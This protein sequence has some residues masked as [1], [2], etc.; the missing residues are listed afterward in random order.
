MS[1]VSTR[2]PP[3]HRRAFTLVEMLIV[4]A[5]ISVLAALL[6]PAIQAAREAARKAQCTNNLRQLGLAIQQ[7]D[8]AKGFYPAS[9]TFWTNAAYASSTNIPTSWSASN[10]ASETLTW[11]HETMPYFERQD[12]RAQIEAN[13]T[14]G[15][16]VYQAAYGRLNIL[17]CPSDP[18]DNS[19]SI[20]VFASPQSGYLPY[21]QLSYGCNSGTSDNL[22]LPLPAYG[23]D[24]PDNGVFENRLKGSGDPVGLRFK[25]P[26]SA[27]VVNG[28]G[29]S[30]TIL[31]GENS[32]LE[33]WNWAPTEYHPGIVW[34]DNY[35]NGQ[36]QFLNKGTKPDPPD[37]NDPPQSPLSVLFSVSTPAPNAA[38]PYARPLS[39]HSSGFMLLFCDGRV[40]FVSEGIAYNVYARLMTSNG[41]K[42]NPAGANP[43]APT[44]A[45]L[46]IRSAL[47]AP[48]NDESY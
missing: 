18:T 40:K 9:R 4:I 37:P 2:R 39:L 34:D 23:F 24:F 12:M 16:T 17:L 45:T 19:T 27:D 21:S 22:A 6:L 31:L 3:R 13:L 41:K 11:V 20:N 8:Q 7:F 36:N 46:G 32:D 42:Y 29:A 14:A 5:I 35:Q 43:A 48:L 30:N 28:D 33:E 25:K 38:F 1:L 47:M 26:T 10:A 15:G 44:A